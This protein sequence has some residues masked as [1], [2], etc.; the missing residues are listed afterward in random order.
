MPDRHFGFA[1]NINKEENKT[2]EPNMKLNM[3]SIKYNKLNFFF[4]ILFNLLFLFIIY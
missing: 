3:P 2:A 4:K 1:A